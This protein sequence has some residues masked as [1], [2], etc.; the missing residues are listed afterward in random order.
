MK[1][2]LN[3]T[4]DDLK[5]RLSALKVSAEGAS[6]R[7]H[8]IKT[9]NLAAKNAEIE[10]LERENHALGNSVSAFT[11]TVD[12]TKTELRLSIAELTIEVSDSISREERT[13]FDLTRKKNHLK[14]EPNRWHPIHGTRVFFENLRLSREIDASYR[15][16]L[17]LQKSQQ[18]LELLSDAINLREWIFSKDEQRLLGVRYFEV[19]KTTEDIQQALSRSEAELASVQQLLLESQERIRQLKE[20]VSAFSASNLADHENSYNAFLREINSLELELARKEDFRLNLDFQM[21]P[22]NQEHRKLVEERRRI[23][24]DVRD[25]DNPGTGPSSNQQRN[26]E[27]IER[28]IAKIESRI[29][30]LVRNATRTVNRI[31]LDGNNLCYE[32]NSPIGLRAVSK[33]A[34]K[35]ATNYEVLVVFDASIRQM[36]KPTNN[37]FPDFPKEVVVHIVNAKTSADE[38]I[39]RLSSQPGQFVISNDRFIDF[40]EA[41]AVSNGR[42]IRHEM[43][44]GHLLVHDLQIDL[45][46]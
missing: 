38:T 3:K 28:S 6:R 39:L 34:T 2:P 22:L 10:R 5:T 1:N 12:R 41:P 24:R 9:F 31:V 46:Y 37:S 43:V 44:R 15:N 7:V 33:L 23:E 20:E 18:R 27:R 40:P 21:I 14:A 45:R 13:K 8:A 16:I 25:G 19:L 32:K 29:A 4:C 36:A 42:I 30:H 11:N 26:L 17:F 35:L